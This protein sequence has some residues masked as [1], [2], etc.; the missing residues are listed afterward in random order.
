MRTY[1][2]S[3][4]HDSLTSWGSYALNHTKLPIFTIFVHSSTISSFRSIP[5][6]SSHLKWHFPHHPCDF[7]VFLL[8]WY[9]QH[10]YSLNILTRLCISVLCVRVLA[11]SLCSGGL[12]IFGPSFW[13]RILYPLIIHLPSFVIFVTF[14][15]YFLHP[16]YNETAIHQRYITVSIRRDV[17]MSISITYDEGEKM[18][19]RLVLF[20]SLFIS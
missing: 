5:W 11:V 20:C 12:H 19:A 4:F 8:L 14:V 15:L 13:V 10:I 1:A 3:A 17:E 6:C 9:L 18:Y 16:L 7:S 2:C